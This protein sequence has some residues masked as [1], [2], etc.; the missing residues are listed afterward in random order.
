MPS[1]QP[2]ATGIVLPRTQTGANPQHLIVT[3]LSD[4]RSGRRE[5]LPSAGLARL[6]DQFGITPTRAR[7]A[8]SR[9][10]RR[11]PLYDGVWVS[12][13]ADGP[14][15]AALLGD[16]GVASAIVLSSRR[17]WGGQPGSGVP[18]SYMCSCPPEATTVI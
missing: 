18:D 12:P 13:R 14:R 10:A 16:L 15:T 17:L 1:P 11:G 8:L 5:H 9:L 6:A 7:A 3:L 4:Y 2:A